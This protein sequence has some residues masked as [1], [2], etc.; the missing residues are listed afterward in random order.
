M[1][2]V[3]KVILVGHL[4]SD[5]EIKFSTTGN[6][7]CTFRIATSKAWRDKDQ[8]QQERTEWH[9]IVVWGKQAEAC[10]QYLRKGASVFVEGEI[11]TRKYQDAQGM[12]RFITEIKARDV[13]FL[14]G[15]G[16]QEVK[17]AAPVLEDMG[18][19]D[20]QSQDIPF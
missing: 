20:T 5:P 6:P 4:G 1:S 11:E 14:G 2:T 18:Y 3:N 16:N 8:V 7:L 13:R 12:E 15:K 9:R 17:A 10:A 19:G